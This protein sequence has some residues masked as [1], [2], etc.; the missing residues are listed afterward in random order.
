MFLKTGSSKK[1]ALF[2]LT[3]PIF[4]ETLLRIL[5]GNVDT[6]MLSSYSDKAVAGVGAANQFVSIIILVYQVVASGSGIIVSQYIGAQNRKKAAE[7]VTVSLLFNLVLGLL[8][9]LIIFLSIDKILGFMGFEKDVYNYAHD[10][11]K[12]YMSFSFVISLSST[13]TAIL[14]SYGLMKFP[15]YAGMGAN[16]LN[17]FG[18]CVVLFGLFG[19]PVLGVKGVAISTVI[20]QF[21]AL[22]IVFVVLVKKVKIDLSPS[23]ILSVGKESFKK[24]LSDIFKIG[25]PSAGE[26]LSYNFS[27]IAITCIITILGTNSLTARFYVFNLMLFIMLFALSIGQATQ[28]QVGYLVGAG[29]TDEAYKTC[30]KSLKISILI[31]FLCAITMAI[32]ARP[33]L[34]LFTKNQEII[35]TGSLL[36]MMTI[37]LEPGRAF[38]IVVGNSLR[39]AGDAKFIMYLGFAS[40]WGV[41]VLISYL[42]GIRAGLGLVGI[43]IGFASDEWLRGIIMLMRWRSRAWEGK[44]VVLEAVKEECLIQQ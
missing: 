9:S 22:V 13:I 29:D 14:R 34:S 38:N 19:M 17:I 43:W 21:V 12:I 36:L 8:M 30:I 35:S 4:I 41:A 26:T 20:S 18:D 24:I 33:L 3:W 7:V 44:S 15:M 2:A 32:S 31:S 28:I 10:F 5:F 27:Q 39:G 25:G 40:M 1:F 23:Y 42:L 11:L 16:I 6:F 37:V